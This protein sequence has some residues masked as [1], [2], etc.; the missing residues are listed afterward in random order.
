MLQLLKIFCDSFFFQEGGRLVTNVFLSLSVLILVFDGL[1]VL[2]E[3]SVKE[4]PTLIIL[5]ALLL[6]MLCHVVAMSQFPQ[7]N[8]KWME[9]VKAFMASGFTYKREAGNKS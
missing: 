4:A 2:A 9:K 3:E 6:A 8:M 5:F 1:L 7:V